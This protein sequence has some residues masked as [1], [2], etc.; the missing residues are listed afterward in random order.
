MVKMSKKLKDI[1]L[2]GI[3]STFVFITILIGGS[4]LNKQK[5]ELLMSLPSTAEVYIKVNNPILIR[6][7]LFD[8]LFKS[9][10]DIKDFKKVDVRKEDISIPI[11]GIDLT[12]E[13][14][15][16]VEKWAG[17]DVVSFLFYLNDREAFGEFTAEYDGFISHSDNDKGCILILPEKYKDNPDKR[18]KFELYAK[19]LLVPN[20]DRSPVKLAFSK[21]RSSS[22]FQFYIKGS[23]ESLL[24]NINFDLILKENTLIVD[25]E[26]EQNPIYYID[27]TAIWKEIEAPN[28]SD[29]LEL[30]SSRLPD[31]LNHFIRKV[32]NELNS[33][34]PDVVSNH[35]YFYGL[36]VDNLAGSI[37]FLP[38]FDGVFRFNDSIDLPKLDS[39]SPKY[40]DYEKDKIIVGNATYFIKKISEKELF[41][42]VNENPTFVETQSMN[43]FEM[44]GDLSSVLNI[45][46]SGI[47]AK[48]TRLLPQIQHT[49]Q[50]FGK[51]EKF[52]VTSL[53]DQHTNKVY[54]NGIMQFPSDQTA[55]IELIKY[56]LK[57]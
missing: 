34:L 53:V 13:A 12:R 38:I 55:S 17:E 50:L 35:L 4:I 6:R 28:K 20:R 42:G 8:I 37:A 2:V 23:E 9:Y 44:Q 5:D 25:G 57:F 11:I 29:Y 52:E 36:E 22:L 49:K 39:L 30:S 56:L 43:K 45:G 48:V 54:I 46:G 24:K 7:L 1:I 19:D 14:Y 16:F 47:I 40:L 3:L 26:A 51:L 31:T 27:T 41:I 33:P 15:F 21:V 32:T 10:F 18:E